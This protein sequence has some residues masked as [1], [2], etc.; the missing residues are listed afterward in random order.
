MMGHKRCH[1]VYISSA[2]WKEHSR[3]CQEDAVDNAVEVFGKL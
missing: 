3:D 1:R 2:Q